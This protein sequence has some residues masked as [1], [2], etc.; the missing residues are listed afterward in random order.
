MFSL[1]TVKLSR[2]GKAIFIIILF[3]SLSNCKS[4]YKPTS[5]NEA[6][7]EKPGLVK[8]TLLNGDE[9]IYSSL[10]TDGTNIYGIQ[11]TK[12]GTDRVLL[13]NEDVKEV[14]RYN[15]SA[16]TCFGILGVGVVAGSAILI[17][18]ML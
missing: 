17:G 14:R 3:L 13:K 6:V 12:E 7:K 10:E 1:F 9:Y 4:Y 5:L 15:K 16:S 18:S 11:E 2:Y 8:L